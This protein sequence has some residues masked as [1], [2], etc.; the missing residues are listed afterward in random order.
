MTPPRLVATDLDG[1]VVR[2]DY[3]VSERTVAAFERVERAG[4]MLVLVT[5]RPPRW[6]RSVAHLVA[7]CGVAICANGAI[8]YD[9]HTERVVDTHLIPAEAL[10]AAIERL[11]AALPGAGFAV[12]HPA[13]LVFAEGYE[14]SH[15][16][17]MTR[18]VPLEE[19]MARP[20]AKLLVRHPELAADALLAEAAEVVGDLVLPTHSNG[21]RLIE[22]SAAGVTKASTLAELCERHGIRASEVAAFG[23]MPNDLPMLTWAGRSY[24]VANAHPAVLAAVDHKVPANDEDGVARTLEELFSD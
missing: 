20:A 12:E 22:M 3:T 11:R 2:S 6:M 10:R 9:M 24:A 13:G 14:V 7:H 1:T 4:A 18:P 19:L 16:D 23:D 8:V 21:D 15:W 5:G 17:L